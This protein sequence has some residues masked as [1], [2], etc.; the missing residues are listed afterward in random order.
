M[1][2][3]GGDDRDGA[4]KAGRG[5]FLLLCSLSVA[6][7]FAPINFSLLGFSTL[8]YYLQLIGLVATVTFVITNVGFVHLDLPLLFTL[9]FCASAL[10]STYLY[11]DISSYYVKTLVYFIQTWVVIN[12]GVH[13]NPDWLLFCLSWVLSAYVLINFVFMLVFLPSHP[14]GFSSETNMEMWL[15]GHK[16]QLRNWMFPLLTALALIDVR[17]G[18]LYNPF[19]CFMMVVCVV[20]VWYANSATSTVLLLAYCILLM[21][22]QFQIVGYK[23]LNSAVASAVYATLFFVVVILRRVP[24][25]GDFITGVLGRDLTF[26]G[27]SEIWDAAISGFIK[28]PVLGVGYHDIETTELI[29]PFNQIVTH[30]HEALLD[31]AYKYGMVGL[32]LASLLGIISVLHLYSNRENPTTV[33]IAS[34]LMCYLICG[35]F[36]ELYNVGFYLILYLG[37]YCIFFSSKS[38]TVGKTS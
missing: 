10:L 36:G 21:L 12:I 20:S 34:S 2:E 1:R 38:S 9:L 25:V 22:Q 5:V 37:C 28:N 29:T 11:G 27:R 30:A 18:R 19:T 32:F 3:I 7:L 35:V 31:T 6:G 26:T 24:I 4:S 16:N 33:V 14:L 15:L 17:K 13:R 23:I 8:S